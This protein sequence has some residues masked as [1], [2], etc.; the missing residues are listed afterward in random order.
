MRKHIWEDVT[1]CN[2]KQNKIAQTLGQYGEDK[3]YM[4]T[5]KYSCKQSYNK[6]QS[7]KQKSPVKCIKIRMDNRRNLDEKRKVNEKVKSKKNATIFGQQ[8]TCSTS[9]GQKNKQA[10][11]KHYKC[12]EKV[13]NKKI[14]NNMLNEK[15]QEMR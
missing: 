7:C 10:K 13:N 5:N 11:K 2:S 15:S 3:K 9:L 4:I 8:G 12:K 14:K 1:K 6:F